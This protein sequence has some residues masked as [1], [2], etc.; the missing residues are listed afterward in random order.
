MGTRKGSEVLDDM[1]LQAVQILSEELDFELAESLAGRLREHLRF[2]WGGQLVYFPKGGDTERRDKEL[3]ADFDGYN[4]A[5]L[6]GKYKVS[7]AHVY[8]I[9]KKGYESKKTSKAVITTP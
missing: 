4:H 7:L 6:V 2:Y 5:E 1:E 8:R 9:I 3:Y